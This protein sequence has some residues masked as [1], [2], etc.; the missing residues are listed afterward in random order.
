MKKG[1]ILF[2]VLTLIIGVGIFWITRDKE[3]S[4]LALLEIKQDLKEC[5][6]EIKEKKCVIK[7]LDGWLFL[8]ESLINIT[9]PWTDNTSSIIA[10]RDSLQVRGITLIVVPVPDK[11]QV[12]SSHYLW[13]FNENLIPFEYPQWVKKL[14]DANVHLIDAVRTFTLIHDSIPMFEP[15][16]SHYTS[17]ARNLLASEV[18]KIFK[19]T[20]SDS[21]KHTYTLKD[22][23]VHGT[24]NL[25][26]LYHDN[27][28]TYKVHELKV[29]TEQGLPFRGSSKAPI[30]ILGDSNT[31][32][33]RPY[34]SDIGSLI[35]YHT[36]HETF[37][38]S[39]VG[40]GNSGPRLFKGKESFLQGK[41]AVV[42]VFDGRELYGNIVKP[43]F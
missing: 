17:A 21:L 19:G 1:I 9:V 28:P 32:Q 24:G 7:S 14:H 34:S 37:T 30:V 29:L 40:A 33:G 31:G 36:G 27:Y 23:I 16:E 25:F 35:A 10:F 13:F 5:G 3:I 12:E 26:Y 4:P 18:A 8:Q 20:I 41:K 15:Y 6:S 2:F 11:L 43:V 42:W 22:T 38:I 39:K